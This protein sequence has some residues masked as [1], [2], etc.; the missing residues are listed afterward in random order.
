MKLLR[1]GPKGAEKPGLL[2]ANNV[3]RDLSSVLPDLTSLHLAPESLQ[4]LRNI[5]PTTLPTIDSNVRLG[6]PYIGM[7]KF[8][9]V[10]L[11]YIDHAE[12]AGLPVPKEPIIFAKWNSCAQGANDPIV[13]PQESIKTDWEVE[14]GIVIGTRA[15]YI[16]A[17]DAPAHIAGY[18]VVNDVSEREYQLERGGQWDRGKGCDTFGP[19][20]PWLV[21]A[22]EVPNPQSLALWLDVNGK[23]Y[24]SGNTSKMVFGIYELIAYI[25]RFTTLEPGDLIST[26]TPPGVGMGQTPPVYLRNGDVVT[27]GIEGLGSQQQVVHSWNPDLL[28]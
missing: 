16:D 26:G 12:E 3:L 13:L 2:D 22:D 17:A 10:G 4:Q 1:Y 7:G 6:L 8:I 25:S 24:Q 19:I 9:C 23:R 21:T 5:D 20:G 18:C 28:G 15:R 14:L 11:N 27:L